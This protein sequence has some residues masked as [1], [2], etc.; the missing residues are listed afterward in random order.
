MPIVWEDPPD[1]ADRYRGPNPKY[2]D[3][4]AELRAHPGRWGRLATG[5][6]RAVRQTVTNIAM[7]RLAAF[8]PAGHFEATSSGTTIHVRYVGEPASPMAALE[9]D[10]LARQGRQAILDHMTGWHEYDHERLNTLTTD[11]LVQ[12]HRD[13]PEPHVHSGSS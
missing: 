1:K 10:V 9:T 5:N 2:A 3:Q 6:I 12:M 13:L 11:T 7:G 8:R 4:A